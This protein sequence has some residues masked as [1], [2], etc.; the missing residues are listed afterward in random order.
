MIK[1]NKIKDN[2][3]ILYNESIPKGKYLIIDEQGNKLGIFEK[4]EALKIAEEK[5][6]DILVVNSNS[7]P[8]IARLIDYSKYRYNQQK[9]I[10]E[11]K[12]KQKIINIKTIRIGPTI[13]LNDLDIKVKNI[14]KFL[15]QGDKVKIMMRFPGRMK[16]HFA[17]G[18]IIL[19]NI[20]TDLKSIAYTETA[21][22]FIGNQILVIL[23]PIK[24]KSI[25]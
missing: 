3:N 9:K 17:S 24:L 4:F 8:M 1:N 5:D 7:N 12:K 19:K 2:F 14:K 23:F 11:M 21:P 22:K 13:S 20:I 10:R 15:S 6:I 25:N 16:V 18:Q